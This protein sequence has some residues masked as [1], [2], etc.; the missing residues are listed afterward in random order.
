MAMTTSLL[1]LQLVCYNGWTFVSSPLIGY[2]E[3]VSMTSRTSLFR[4]TSSCLSSLAFR[5][6]LELS[7][8]IDHTS[9]EVVLL[10]EYVMSWKE[11]DKVCGGRG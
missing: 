5:G 11:G 9:I 1:L 8:V 10:L 4:T 6:S 7:D 3:K 2:L